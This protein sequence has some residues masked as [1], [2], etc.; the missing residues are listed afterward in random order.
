MALC[1]HGTLAAAGALFAAGNAHRTLTFHTLSGALAATR[2][3]DD[4]ART[5]PPLIELDFPM[6]E[7]TVL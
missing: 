7:P 2:L 4:A 3:G 6:N 5:C 1:G